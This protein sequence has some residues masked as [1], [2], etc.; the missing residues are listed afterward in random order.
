ML[1][2]NKKGT[3]LEPAYTNKS[4]PRRGMWLMVLYVWLRSFPHL[5]WRRHRFVKQHM[6]HIETPYLLLSSHGCILDF[7]VLAKLFFPKTPGNVIALD[8]GVKREKP[9]AWTGSFLTRKFSNDPTIARNMLHVLRKQ[10]R[11]MSLF[12]EARYTLDG[13]NQVIPD[14]LG[15]LA[16]LM[17]VPVVVLLNP[18]HHLVKPYWHPYRRKLRSE[19]FLTQV[20]TREQVQT[21]SVDAINKAI[22]DAFQYDDYA[23][24][25][26]NNIL[27]RD[28]HRAV[29]LENILY[30]CPICEKEH[31]MQSNQADIS[32]LACGVTHMLS[33]IGDLIEHST[34]ISRT[35]PEWY[36]KQKETLVKEIE[37]QTYHFEAEVDLYMLPNIK[38]FIPLGKAQF[39]HTTEALII[40]FDDAGETRT[41]RREN[42][43]QMA[44]HVAYKHHHGKDYLSYSVDGMTYFLGFDGPPGVVTKLS[45]AVEVFYQRAKRTKK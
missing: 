14:T 25:K 5:F 44:V 18:G 4:R 29:G 17:G 35:V 42:Q 33:E 27:I 28:K 38:G 12:P 32:C 21:M 24:Q 30:R 40:T 1:K 20:L 3:R 34:H 19:S 45:L 36:D 9:V 31:T 41:V 13:R 15:K 43:N 39:K 11:S 8:A 10:N 2:L 26:E 6:T 7:K 23:W 16:K 22:H 37:A